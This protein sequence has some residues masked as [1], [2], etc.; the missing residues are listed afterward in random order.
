E[1][2]LSTK[3]AAK[4]RAQIRRIAQQLES[5]FRGITLPAGIQLRGSESV[6]F[7]TL[8]ANAEVLG[9][10]RRL[11]Y[12]KSVAEDHPEPLP[13]PET[14]GEAPAPPLAS[15]PEGQ[16][17]TNQTWPS[18]D[19]KQVKAPDAWA[20]GFDGRGQTIAVVDTGVEA[21]HPYLGGKVAEQACYSLGN[22]CP[23]GTPEQVGPG[24]AAPCQAPECKHGT[25]VAGIAA[26]RYGV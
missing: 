21:N 9:V 4:Q 7:V 5:R 17:P 12:V 3:D 11:R 8:N 19:V 25:H 10:L 14:D 26:G 1:G 6:P 2:Y 15:G 16:V 24:A 22:A 18:W 20:Q 13:P 23:N